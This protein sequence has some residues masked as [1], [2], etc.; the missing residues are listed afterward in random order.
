MAHELT[1]SYLR[2][3]LSLFRYYKTLTERAMAQ[4]SDTNSF[5]PFWMAR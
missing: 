1:T 5:S 2:D 3:S 4:V